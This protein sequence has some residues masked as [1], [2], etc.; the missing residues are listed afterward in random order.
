M[1][2]N[3][4]NRL[5]L[6]LPLTPQ[7]GSGVKKGAEKKSEKNIPVEK[8][9]ANPVYWQGAVGVKKTS[10]PANNA[11]LIHSIANIKSDVQ[12][13]NSE[14]ETSTVSEY[15]NFLLSQPAGFKTDEEYKKYVLE[16]FTKN[17]E[18]MK[19]N[20]I[21]FGTNLVMNILKKIQKN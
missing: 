13:Q 7:K 2:F 21:I 16:S 18:D 19:K 15:I 17:L 1:E 8:S 3:E 5:N 6:N 11:N 14:T 12:I 4:L 20:I 9:P 10:I